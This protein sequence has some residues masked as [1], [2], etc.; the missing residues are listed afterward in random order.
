M[1]ILR[2]TSTPK[3]LPGQQPIRQPSP[4]PA[5]PDTLD[6]GPM[7][8]S[9]R[10]FN[11]AFAR[12]GEKQDVEISHRIETSAT[13]ERLLAVGATWDLIHNHEL[14]R[15]GKVD[16]GHVVDRLKAIG[17]CDGNSMSFP[18]NEVIKVL[19]ESVGVPGDEL[20]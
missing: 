8:Y 9:P 4:E 10:T 17:I 16:L 19:E 20:I 15:Q 11:A 12:K 2:A 7:V 18:E 3:R 6:T 1:E 14:G 5:D 13:G